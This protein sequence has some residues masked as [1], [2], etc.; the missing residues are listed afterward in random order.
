[1]KDG[2]MKIVEDHSIEDAQ[3]YSELRA[4]F[5]ELGDIKIPWYVD[6][7]E[8][9]TMYAPT[10]LRDSILEKSVKLYDSG[11]G[12]LPEVKSAF[13]AFLN[14]GVPE[15]YEANNIPEGIEDMM[16]ADE[17]DY[18]EQIVIDGKKYTIA[19]TMENVIV[20][21]R[22]DL[23]PL[24]NKVWD[25][26]IG[27]MSNHPRVS[28]P[29][30]YDINISF[31]GLENGLQIDKSPAPVWIRLANAIGIKTPMRFSDKGLKFQET[32]I[33]SQEYQCLLAQV[34]N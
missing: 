23:Q 25:E 10:T 3:D 9:Q 29:Y 31:C 26:L 24:Y 16:F 27:D 18:G 32:E 21:A 7:E 14:L 11:W 33:D 5:S 13:V 12:Y 2:L 17:T 30:D 6:A 15:N 34:Y 22:A 4:F 1:M 19:K 28:R 8:L 20:A